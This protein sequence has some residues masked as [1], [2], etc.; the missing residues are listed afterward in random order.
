MFGPAGRTYTV[1]KRQH[2]RG[3]DLAVLPLSGSVIIVASLDAG[4]LEHV[5]QPGRPCFP[6][7]SRYHV[8][9]GLASVE[10]EVSSVGSS[11]PA[12]GLAASVG[13]TPAHKIV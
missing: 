9:Y 10:A 11:C 3:H 5:A 7:T 4:S 6:R 13:G 1:Y 12:M 2:C 8:S